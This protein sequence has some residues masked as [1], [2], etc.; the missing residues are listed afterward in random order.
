M[1][2]TVRRRRRV[3]RCLVLFIL[4]VTADTGL[5]RVHTHARPAGMPTM[6][7]VV[8]HEGTARKL[9]V[10]PDE[11]VALLR[12][13]I[14]SLTGVEIDE[15]QLTGLGPGVLRDDVDQL[16]LSTL[17]LQ[18]GTWA[19]L[20]RKA[21]APQPMVSPNVLMPRQQQS[22]AE[23]DMHARLLSGLAT[24]RMYEQPALLRAAREAVPW[25]RLVASAMQRRPVAARPSADAPPDAEELHV[26]LEWFKK[27]FFSW[28][29]KPACEACGQPT[30]H[31]GMGVPTAD[32]R[33]GGA[34]RVE[35]Y[36][37]PTGHVTRFPRFN[38]PGVLLQTRR[39]RCGE[40]ANAFTLIAR[41]VGFD[42][43]WVLDV[44]D[45]VWTEV[46]S[47]TQARWLHAD[48]CEATC[49]APM[50]YER[51][52]GKKLSYVIAFGP[53][54]VVDVSRRYAA[55]WT[56]TLGRRTA[57]SE[58]WL[59]EKIA[60]LNATCQAALPPSERSRLAERAAREERLLTSRV[61][62]SSMGATRALQPAE[63]RGRQTGSLEWRQTRGEAGAT[64]GIEVEREHTGGGGGE[65]GRVVRVCGAVGDVVHGLVFELSSG[66]RLGTCLENSLEPIIDLHDEE[67][68]ARRCG[69]WES[70]SEHE[71][72]VAVSGRASRIGF[73]CGEIKLTLSSGRVIEFRGGN[74]EAYAPET[75]SQTAADLSGDSSGA[76]SVGIGCVHF[77][78]GELLCAELLASE[79]ESGGVRSDPSMLWSGDLVAVVSS[80]GGAQLDIS[81]AREPGKVESWA[82]R[83]RV[84]RLDGP[85]DGP[86]LCSHVVGLFSDGCG[87]RL[88]LSRVSTPCVAETEGA[89]DGQDGL[90]DGPAAMLEVRALD[91]E[92]PLDEPLR[93][94]QAVGFFCTAGSWTKG[95]GE[96]P[97]LTVVAAREWRL[98][99]GPLPAQADSLDEES[100]GTRLR[101]LP[102]PRRPAVAP[103]S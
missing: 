22:Q 101:I 40:W 15:Q 71:V 95:A 73:L 34:S 48:P 62:Q 4:V 28:V 68:L 83:F 74:P 92:S 36:R 2:G 98:S 14:W 30:E 8:L 82:T 80:S 86:V 42:A 66:V 18:E 72:I 31:V 87:R 3:R 6:T 59:S 37:G 90:V 23:A 77:A 57:V 41:A 45:H 32:E 5:T 99:V 13:Q 96:G 67:A 88:N 27:E 46:W 11:P 26:L 19:V 63:R 55:T 79:P 64:E 16:P 17:R 70:L 39:G 7:L 52:W 49:D 47:A 60:H 103:T 75:F 94:H 65:S 76:V 78:D 38:N 21:P 54:E 56:A 51:G 10:D 100:E 1:Y 93:Y 29:D 20:D 24:A 44:T 84:L 102:V 25:E 43:R 69:L 97:E 9:A 35:L 85:S 12:H 53:S 89:C 50:T 91:G 81:G 61:Q 58:S 33:A